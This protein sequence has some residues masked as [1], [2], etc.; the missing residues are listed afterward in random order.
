VHVI[1]VAKKPWSWTLLAGLLAL[2]LA[3]CGGTSGSTGGSGGSAGS[4][5]SGGGSHGIRVVMTEFKY[6]PST[7]SASAGTVSFDLV[8]QGRTAHDM[9]VADSSGKVLGKSSLVGAGQEAEFSVQVS[10]PGTYQIYC[11]LPGHR[12]AGMSGTLE[13]S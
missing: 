2:S 9:V 8:N 10:Q 1:E 11:D 6:S 13:V 5:G 4:A 12:E 3:A 7:I